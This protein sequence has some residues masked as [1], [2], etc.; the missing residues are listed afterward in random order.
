MPEIDTCPRCKRYTRLDALSRA[1]NET[2]VCSECGQAE[3]WFQY[4]HRSDAR[5]LPP[6]NEPVVP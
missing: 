5:V 2:L 3:A 4:T 1:D 6:V